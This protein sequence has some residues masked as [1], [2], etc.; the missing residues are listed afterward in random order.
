[1]EIVFN[2]TK[3]KYLEIFSLSDLDN[4]HETFKKFSSVF[5]HKVNLTLKKNMPIKK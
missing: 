1:M 3:S 5:I 2:N 4:I